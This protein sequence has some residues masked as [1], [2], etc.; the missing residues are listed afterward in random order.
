[1]KPDYN[2]AQI[3]AHA[4]IRMLQVCQT[5]LSAMQH[6]FKTRSGAHSA[7]SHQ[8][9]PSF[10]YTAAW[11]MRM[12]RPCP[13][14]HNSRCRQSSTPKLAIV[15]TIPSQP[16]EWN[17]QGIHVLTGCPPQVPTWPVWVQAHAEI[18]P[19]PKIQQ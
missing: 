6:A 18:P 3:T 7:T 11:L 9:V 17:G 8:F 1:V 15:G 13:V 19:A 12:T 16:Q 14:L 10:W 4:G 5:A 2:P